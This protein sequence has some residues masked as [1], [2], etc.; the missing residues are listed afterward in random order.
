MSERMGAVLRPMALMNISSGLKPE[1]N[2]A[3]ILCVPGEKPGGLA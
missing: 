1:F 3:L 2:D